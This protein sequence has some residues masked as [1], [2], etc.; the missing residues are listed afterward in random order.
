M[1]SGEVEFEVK[2]VSTTAEGTSFGGGEREP[3]SLNVRLR[4]ENGSSHCSSFLEDKVMSY[5]NTL[6]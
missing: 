5:K 4:V 1:A 2:G 3:Q 6:Q